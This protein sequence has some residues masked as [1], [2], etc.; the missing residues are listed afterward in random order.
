MRSINGIDRIVDGRV[1]DSKAAGGMDRCRLCT[2]RANNEQ[3]ISVPL[4][5]RIY[6]GASRLIAGA[7]NQYVGCPVHLGR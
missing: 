3:Q 5:D 1:H 2:W 6:R 4:H 7:I